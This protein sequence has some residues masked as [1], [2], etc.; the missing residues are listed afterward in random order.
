MRRDNINYLTVGV[1]VVAMVAGLF[2]VLYQ[3]TGRTGPSD[4]YHTFYS[5]VSG[6]KYGT[7]VY[8]EGYPIGQVE[9]L[10]PVSDP[11]GGTRYR[12]DLSVQEGWEIPADSV[13]RIIASGLLAAVSI[14]IEEG[15]S[16]E[17]LEP[18]DRV[19]GQD[20]VNLF[21][22]IS[23]IAAH[24]GDLSD[25]GIKPVL[26][27]LDRRISELSTE[28]TDLSVS[29]I[30]PFVDALRE[31]MGDPRMWSDLRSS[32]TN[33]ERTAEGMA[34]MVDGENRAMVK[35]I[36]G[37]TRNASLGL[38]E[39]MT[40]IED[41]RMRMNVLLE[42]VDALV[43]DNADPLRSTVSGAERAIGDL[44]YS[45]QEISNHIDAV[46]YHLEGS[47]RNVNEFTRY[48]RENPSAL[49]RGTSDAGGEQ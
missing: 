24:F 8:Y 25:R 48:V 38:D 13:A 26:E 33:L 4:Q 34:E 47:V 23:D 31:R 22:A 46:M 9:A 17:M 28:Y 45:V 41:T 49:I 43:M 30:R 21:A 44:E 35:A 37:N 40:R 10:T 2:V 20:H 14:E 6:I 7:G 3:I 1:F 29:T 27:N 16:E 39:L 11:E 19:A 15:E 42:D 18:G 32:I 5:N 36:L 12:V